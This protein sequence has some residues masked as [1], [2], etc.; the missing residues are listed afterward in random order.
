MIGAMPGR[1][2]LA[3]VGGVLALAG[4]PAQAAPTTD[5]GPP[6]VIVQRSIRGIQLGM[7]PA[8]VRELLDRAPG[9]RWRAHEG[10]PAITSAFMTT[11]FRPIALALTAA[12][13]VFSLAA[14][15]SDN[16]ESAVDKATKLANEQVTNPPTITDPAAD[17]PTLKVV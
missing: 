10:V 11:R 1:L 12:L 5:E 13:I 16:Q 14:C 4:S 6:P 7:D 15:G 17:A 9:E 3:L 2:A 8:R